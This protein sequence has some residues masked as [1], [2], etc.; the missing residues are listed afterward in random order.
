MRYEKTGRHMRGQHKHPL[1]AIFG[2]EHHRRGGGRHRRPDDFES[3]GPRRRFFDQGDLRLVL[4]KLI[5]DEPRHGYDCIRA[6][7]ALT[8]GSYA[9]S[10][11]VVYPTLSL[12]D[13]MGLIAE[14]PGEEKRRKFA[15]TE[16]GTTHL[17]ENAKLVEALFARMEAAGQARTR[18]ED[19]PV[20]RAMGNLKQVLM[21]RMS[22]TEAD[23][24]TALA[25]AAAIDEAAQKIERL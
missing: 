12:L 18:T 10:P 21:Q 25:I 1:H 5:S 24:D 2:G 4:L 23:R 20:R 14:A 16:A 9:P 17:A 3:D 22:A 8:G 7:E 6:I 19:V 15:I 11:G 13:E